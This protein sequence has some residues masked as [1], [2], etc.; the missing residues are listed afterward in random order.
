MF[1]SW[2]IGMEAGEVSMHR[3]GR[4]VCCQ[5][6]AGAA[7]VWRT[8]VRWGPTTVKL[9]EEGIPVG[10]RMRWGKPELHWMDATDIVLIGS[11]EYRTQQGGGG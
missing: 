1:F 10:R 4:S 8:W 5:R 11:G 6:R 2:R 9:D 3:S 7:A